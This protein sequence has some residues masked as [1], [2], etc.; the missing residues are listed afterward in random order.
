[1]EL[2]ERL[3]PDPLV[4][5]A[6]ADDLNTPQA[7][8]RLQELTSGVDADT[9]PTVL[10]TVIETIAFLGF[11]LGTTVGKDARKS[12]EEVLD[13]F[14][15]AGAI[16]DAKAAELH[17]ARMARDFQKADALREEME[18]LGVT[19]QSTKDGTT[20]ERTIDFDPTKLEALK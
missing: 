11:R 16:L 5:A 13:G 1:M 6:L 10:S 17:E 12:I 4:V 15:R 3:R 19:V 2:P 18:S 9:D 7:I 14:E 20:W 8:R